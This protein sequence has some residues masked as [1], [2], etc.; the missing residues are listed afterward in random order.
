MA[1]IV[2]QQN[3]AKKP[4]P[5]QQDT[6]IYADIGPS[7]LSKR[8]KEF[9][10]LKLDDMHGWQSGV[11]TIKSQFTEAMASY[12]NNQDFLAGIS[13]NNNFLCMQL[14]TYDS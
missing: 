2:V 11:C 6:L 14:A 1:I 8:G 13:T 5:V 4:D 9:V 12:H 3:L 7:S 10:T